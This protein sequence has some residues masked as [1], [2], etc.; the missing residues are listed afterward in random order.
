MLSEDARKLLCF[1]MLGQFL[2]RLT[3][4]FAPP[5]NVGMNVA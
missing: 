3:T 1:E 2:D 5:A 4:D